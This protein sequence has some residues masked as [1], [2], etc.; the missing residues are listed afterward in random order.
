MGVT[1]L[2]K[3]LDDLDLGETKDL[4]SLSGKRIAVDTSGWVVQANTTKGL[5]E[6]RAPYLRNVFFRA[7]QLLKNGILPIF[8][9]EGKVPPLKEAAFKDRNHQGTSQ[10]STIGR[11][12]FDRI[13][14]ECKTLLQSLG[15]PCIKS[16]GEAEAL[17]SFLYINKIVDA[18]MTEDSDAFL[19]GADIV[20]R[21]FTANEQE[22]HF[23][24]YSLKSLKNTLDLDQ[25]K[26]IALALLLGCDYDEDGVPGI[27]KETAIKFLSELNGYDPL[28]RFLEWK[29]KGESEIYP[30]YDSSIKKQGVHCKQCNHL[31]C[32]S[33][34]STTGCTM[35]KSEIS[36]FPSDGKNLCSCAFHKTQ[37]IR[38]HHKAELKIYH[39]AREKPNFPN[40][41]IVKEFKNYDDKTPDNSELEWDCPNLEKFQMETLKFLRWS[42]EDSHKKVFSLIT[43]W[44]QLQ[45]SQNNISSD[46]L[47]YKPVKIVKKRTKNGK[48]CFE[49]QWSKTGE[50]VSDASLTNLCTIEIEDKFKVAYPELSEEFYNL[51][52][53]KNE[54]KA[55]AKS[56]KNANK[57]K[58][59]TEFYSATKHAKRARK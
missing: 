13:L 21:G 47:L 10:S 46:R 15:V 42:S 18:V 23:K 4:S 56:P 11:A 17:C 44:Q 34:H 57:N 38:L 51:N 54:T 5:N 29:Q 50:D 2:W 20:L 32:L 27:G 55:K 14:N 9:L 59:M 22:S 3:I 49:V 53:A 43:L 1:G 26:L 39:A 52:T 8:V 7:N 58:K 12:K 6:S 41:E 40:L 48:G 33:E 31:G 30:G 24:E 36:C 19:Y 25:E 28:K 35:C 45:L 37:E 16:S